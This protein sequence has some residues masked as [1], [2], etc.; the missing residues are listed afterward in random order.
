MMNPFQAG[1]MFLALRLHFTRPS[2]DYFKYH[3]KT[4]LT[5]E[6]FALRSDKFL[7]AKLVRTYTEPEQF[8]DFVIAN[9]LHD[10]HLHSRMLLT[11]EARDN[12]L[13]YR[14]VHESLSYVVE[15]DCRS[16]FDTHNNLNEWFRVRQEYP[17][18]LT[19]IWQKKMRLETL[20]ILNRVFDFLPMWEQNIPDTIKWP[21][22]LLV[23]K[24]YDPFVIGERRKYKTL[25]RSL[26]T[27]PTY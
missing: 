5:P 6:K 12:Y 7:F 16:F 1:E 26:L 2:Y 20:I 21:A 25:L 22:F 14:K 19:A 15:Q 3:G 17:I 10:S 13:A 8:Q 27:I 9:C 23:W 4:T 18:L 24:K 11:P